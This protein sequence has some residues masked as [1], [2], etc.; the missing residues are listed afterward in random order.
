M[1]SF[2][3][4]ESKPGMM[5]ISPS[6][7]DWRVSAPPR[8][9]KPAGIF[10]LLFSAN[11]AL[12]D[13]IAKELAAA[14]LEKKLIIP[15]RL[16]NIAPKGA[17][18]YELASR[19]W[20]NAFD[21]TEAKLAEL[22]RGLAHL[23]KTGGRDE[24][25]LPFDRSGAGQSPVR[26]GRR[27]AFIGTGAAALVIAAIA[28][29]VMLWPV[30]HWTVESSRP[31]IS[32]LALEGEPA[33][34]PD[35][36]MLAWRRVPI[37]RSRKIYVRSIAGGNGIK[38]IND[39]YDDS[40]PSWSPDGARLAYMAK[41]SGA[42]P[43]ASWSPAFRAGEARQGRALR[44]HGGIHLDLL[45]ARYLVP[46]LAPMMQPVE[47][48]RPARNQYRCHTADVRHH[49]AARSQQRGEA[50]AAQGSRTPFA[51]MGHLQYSPDGKFASVHG[52]RKRLDTMRCAI[53][54]LASGK[55]RVLGKVVIGGSAAW[56][57]DSRSCLIA[58]AS[59]IGSEIT[60]FHPID[61]TGALS[62][63]NIGGAQCQPFGGEPGGLL[64]LETDPAS[65]NKRYSANTK[66]LG[67]TRH[68]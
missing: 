20:V 6:G 42:S 48:Y 40:S 21:D 32:T 27:L 45:A 67:A 25:V 12:S 41:S 16:E 7:E 62:R 23:V 64:A 3:P 53:R 13:D 52:R 54:D 63:L 8:R 65:R 51:T 4:K 43:A 15:V 36:K 31:F 14:T 68:H 56:S 5:P 18:L 58:T 22:A 38:L 2:R 66:P 61:G 10:V 47:H 9:W 60:Y 46:L 24:S 11:A 30:P 37:A 49:R 26:K 1:P 44:H 50:D 28:A 57:E 39:G 59:G 55:E 29:A 17:F 19:N 33:F 35:G 34:S